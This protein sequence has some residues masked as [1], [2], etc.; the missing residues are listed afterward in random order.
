MKVVTDGDR[1]RVSRVFFREGLSGK[2]EVEALT[3]AGAIGDTDR[4]VLVGH[5]R[6]RDGDTV[7]VEKQ[8]LA[9]GSAESKASAP[10]NG[11]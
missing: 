9:G 10:A 4:I 3:D 1:L 5:D 7:N 2:E 6:L 8:T 11:G